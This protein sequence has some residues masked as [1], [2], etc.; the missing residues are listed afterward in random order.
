MVTSF[1]AAAARKRFRIE[2]WV[3][4]D[5]PRAAIRAA[6]VRTARKEMAEM[7]NDPLLEDDDLEELEEEDEDGSLLE[8]S[9]RRG[10]DPEDLPSISGRLAR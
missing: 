9:G 2:G 6:G 1:P 8:P 5:L 7:E 10:E 4:T 3:V